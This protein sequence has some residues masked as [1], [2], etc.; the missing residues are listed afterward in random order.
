MVS[1]RFG[2][3]RRY[4]PAICGLA[5]LVA[6][7]DRF[8]Q[9]LTEVLPV[10]REVAR[11]VSGSHVEVNVTNARYLTIRIP[12]S[13]IRQLTQDEKAQKTLEIARVGYATYPL[14]A[15][16]ERVDVVLPSAGS[17][18]SS[19]S[20]NR[21]GQGDSFSYRS[22]QLVAGTGLASSRMPPPSAGITLYVVP[23]GEI[24][25]KYIDDLGAY[26]RARFPVPLTILA[27]LAFDRV[28]YDGVR[29]MDTCRVSG[30]SMWVSSRTPS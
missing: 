7:C 9:T 16:L 24:P 20:T 12:N 28:T 27:P 29:S 5:L 3:R 26:I 4:V 22:S 19:T 14:R 1:R 23:I 8:S 15:S 21:V 13:P 11:L 6:A 18:E 30:N 2:Q 10:Q 17:D 25:T